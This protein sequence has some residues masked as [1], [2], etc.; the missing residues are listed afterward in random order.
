MTTDLNT[1]LIEYLVEA[2]MGGIVAQLTV[3]AAAMGCASCRS[4]VTDA[5]V[6]SAHI[7]IVKMQGQTVLRASRAELIRRLRIAAGVEEDRLK[8][9][10][11]PRI[12]SPSDGQS[13]RVIGR[14]FPRYLL[15]K[16]QHG[17]DFGAERWLIARFQGAGDV[18]WTKGSSSGGEYHEGDLTVMDTRKGRHLVNRRILLRGGRLTLDR[19]RSDRV[20]EGIK[21]V[22]DLDDDWTRWFVNYAHPKG[23]A[24]LFSYSGSVG[25]LPSDRVIKSRITGG[26]WS[27]R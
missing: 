1:K 21:A 20:L 15:P 16:A 26:K 5:A 9:Q 4:R 13:I 8:P 10:P 22:L 27:R 14:R 25:D 18:F 23:T 11:P 19:L 2:E 3:D 24:Y 6:E 12:P 17:C 7:E